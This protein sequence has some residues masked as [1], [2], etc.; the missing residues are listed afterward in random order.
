M[1]GL[2]LKDLY[3][4]RFQVI[5]GIL[6][7]LIP[8]IVLSLGGAAMDITNGDAASKML[9]ALL[10]AMINY[11]NICLFSSF[12]LNTLS[13][14]INSG[15][16]KIELTFPVSGSR[17]IGAK[18]IASGLVVAL[19]TLFSL[20]FNVLFTLMFG[21]DFEIMIAL[22]ICI[23]LYQMTLLAPLFP[24]AKRIGVKFTEAMYI[25]AQ[26]IMLALAVFL[27]IKVVDN[28][29]LLR[30]VFYCGLPLLALVSFVLS[31]LF[32]KSA[33]EKSRL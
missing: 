8:N 19:L 11:V 16:A 2:V 18:L 22:P 6:I 3:S 26:V 12:V 25:F 1:K 29:L 32:G 21:M 23:G 28:I 24:I 17:I 13:T 31:F 9:S 27:F 14:D 30:I 33:V 10:F 4:V 5:V 15:W 20:V 7:M